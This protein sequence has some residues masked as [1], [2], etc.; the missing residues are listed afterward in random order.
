MSSPEIFE[1][2][3]A[4]N[5]A[6]F[7]PLKVDGQ[8]GPATKNAVMRFQKASGLMADGVVGPKTRAKLGLKA[9]V[10]RDSDPKSAPKASAAQ[11]EWP[12]QKDVEEF[13]GPPAGTQATAGSVK[14]P[15]AM[16]I[17]WNTNQTIKAFPC[18]S[19]VVVPMTTIFEETV[20][21]YGEK[22]WRELG[23]DLFGGCYNPRKMRGGNSWSM[24]A[25]GIAVDIDP[26]RNQLNMGR[27]VAELAKPVY[28]PFWNIVEGQ[29]ALSLG[30]ARN[31]DWMHF[32]F[33][34][35]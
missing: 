2:Q 21:H 5:A 24:H 10:D 15:V 9:P 22:E 18:H 12:R 8:N 25:W 17:A 34:R 20:K 11:K 28:D 23:L 27:D 33:A 26:I 14:L 13:Y 3:T 16:R 32:Q 31:F 6:G 1:L 30:R 19:K 4:L 7:G 29:G 35:L